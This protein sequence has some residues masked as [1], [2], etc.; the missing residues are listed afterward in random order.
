MYLIVVEVSHL[1]RNLLK[2][3]MSLL[4]MVVSHLER[5]LLKK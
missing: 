4:I 1:E 3:K 5:K 2:K